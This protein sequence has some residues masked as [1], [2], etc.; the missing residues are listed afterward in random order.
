[1]A[2]RWQDVDYN[3]VYS[4]GPSELPTVLRIQSSIARTPQE[5]VP[6]GILYQKRIPFSPAGI[7]LTPKKARSE[8]SV[9]DAQH[10]Q[11]RRGSGSGRKAIIIDVQSWQAALFFCGP[12]GVNHE[13]R[14]GDKDLGEKDHSNANKEK[15]FTRAL[16]LTTLNKANP[17]SLPFQSPTSSSWRE[18]I[19]Y[20]HAAQVGFHARRVLS[21]PGSTI[22]SV[23]EENSEI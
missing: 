9:E 2:L 8:S 17:L 11:W 10:G 21:W 13:R 3:M 16:H 6:R 18:R 23:I 20:L 4:L 19:R 15:R 14:P 22:L 12:P 1:M 7:F 5:C